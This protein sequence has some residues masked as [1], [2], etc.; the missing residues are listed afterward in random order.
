MSLQ[1]HG[2]DRFRRVSGWWKKATRQPPVIATL[3][4]LICFAV[5][6]TAFFVGNHDDAVESRASSPVG[7]GKRQSLK[8]STNTDVAEQ[9]SEKLSSVEWLALTAASPEIRV[10]I[11]PRHDRDAIIR[12]D[13]RCGIHLNGEA[14]LEVDSI[15]ES[16]VVRESDGQIRLG[17]IAVPRTRGTNKPLIEIIPRSTNETVSGHSSEPSMWL[18]QTLYRG[19]LAVRI[20]ESGRIRFVNVLPIEHYLASVIDSE[21]PSTFSQASRE[22]QAVVSR[23]YA[24]AHMKQHQDRYYDVTATTRH[25]RY[26]GYHYRDASGRLLAGESRG[27]RAIVEK[28]FGQV[29]THRGE[30]FTAYFSANCGGRTTLPHWESETHKAT[31]GPIKSVVDPWCRGTSLHSWRRKLELGEVRRRL[32]KI[33]NTPVD[34]IEIREVTQTDHED[35]FSFQAANSHYDLKAEVVRS[36]LFQGVS[37]PSRRFELELTEEDLIAHGRG[38]GHGI[39]FCQWGANKQ[40]AS[41]RSCE[42]I[43]RFYYPGVKLTRMAYSR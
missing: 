43:I 9:G 35:M 37:F 24:L 28:T 6:A 40:G 23:T 36:Q 22:A 31:S 8:Q 18:H 16:R 10:E 38:H 11:S 14:V 17:N 29:A 25:Q 30:I 21:M 39:G 5:I 27:S 2:G 20:N 33:V 32:G 4:T 12:C 42:E 41:G 15:P 34:Q 1:S 19:R 13:R 26:L 7:A 3:A